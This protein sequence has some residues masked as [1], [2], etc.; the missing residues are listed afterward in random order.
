MLNESTTL[1]LLTNL[2]LKNVSLTTMVLRVANSVNYNPRGKPI[3]SVSRAVTMMGWD[4]ISN[5][6]SGVLVFEHFRNQSDKLKEL[7]L[8]MMLTGN[9]AR[10]I[11]IRSGMRGI[12]EAYLCGMFRNLGEL[13]IACYLPD[14]YAAISEGMTE[15]HLSE[16]ESCERILKFRYEELGK[17]VS[18]YWNLPETVAKCMENPDLSAL[19]HG[20]IEQLRVITSFSHALSAVVYRKDPSESREA[21]T[22]LVK[23]YG[24]ALPIA[25]SDIPAVLEAAAVETQDTFRAAHIPMDRANLSRQIIAATNQPDPNRKDCVQELLAEDIPP[26]EQTDV[27]HSLMKELSGMIESGDDFDLNA[28]LMMILEAFYRGAGLDRVLFC[29]VDGERTHVQAR[30]G[31][32]ADFET[33]LEKFHFPI[34]LRS[35]PLG[36]AMLRK[37]DIIVDASTG[38]R[39]SRSIFMATIAAPCFGILP[40]VVDGIVAGCFYFDSASYI[41]TLDASKRKALSELRN[42]ATLAIARRRKAS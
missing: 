19:E 14:E 10:Q 22:A 15:D 11:A 26:A 5:L 4:S 21:L 24:A 17:G 42:F 35:G 25:A 8:L 30:L 36:S 28:L 32:G 12:E 9:H 33:L 23:K 16:A 7:V 39:Y 27:L 40:L 6:A 31:M 18:R 38:V 37:E 13:V 3:L 1:N 41:F 2:I 20:E 29:L 34:S